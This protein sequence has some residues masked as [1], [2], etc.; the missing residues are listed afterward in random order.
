MLL[1]KMEVHLGV[2]VAPS[3]CATVVV[4]AAESEKGVLNVHAGH[5]PGAVRAAV[6]A[7]IASAFATEDGLA[8]AVAAPAK[9]H[10]LVQ[11]R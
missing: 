4:G 3:D 11:L 10:L 6:L 7:I 1:C 8:L 2:P 5:V 9:M